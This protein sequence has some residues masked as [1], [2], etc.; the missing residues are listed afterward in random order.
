MTSRRESGGQVR[1][2]AVSI[3]IADSWEPSI[4]SRAFMVGLLLRR[5][6]AGAGRCARAGG[7]DPAMTDGPSLPTAARVPAPTVLCRPSGLIRT[8]G[9]RSSGPDG[10]NLAE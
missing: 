7:P 5:C 10:G 3:A 2:A 4:A 8:I 9:P 6:C 1:L